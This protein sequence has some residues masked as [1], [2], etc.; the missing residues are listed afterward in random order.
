[1][2]AIAADPASHPK[3]GPFM[4]GTKIFVT[5]TFAVTAAVFTIAN[6]TAAHGK[7]RASH[8]PVSHLPAIRSLSPTQVYMAA[9]TSKP[10]QIPSNYYFTIH[11]SGFRRRDII[12]CDDK[13]MPK[14]LSFKFKSSHELVAKISLDQVQMDQRFERGADIPLT[15]YDPVSKTTSNSV[16]I[17]VSF[18]A[19]GG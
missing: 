4:S 10:E 7:P 14:Q 6:D 13:S 19:L 16:T 18:M 8:P 12:Q 15:V 3:R 2:L 11:G 5:I 17:K 1:L 9:G